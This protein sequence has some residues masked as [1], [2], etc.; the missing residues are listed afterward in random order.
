MCNALSPEKAVMWT[1][2]FEGA[3]DPELRAEH[4]THESYRRWFAVMAQLM[5][6]GEAVNEASMVKRSEASGHAMDRLEK[7][8]L[9]RMLRVPPP[10]RVRANR[11]LLVQALADRLLGKRVHIERLIN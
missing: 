7:R 4:F 5:Q 3:P 6:D 1:L 11:S 2:L 10:P 9:Q 8:A